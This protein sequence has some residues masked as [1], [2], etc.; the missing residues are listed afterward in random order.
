[1]TEIEIS[2]LNDDLSLRAHAV[3]PG[4]HFGNMA[5]D[6]IIARGGDLESAWHVS[7]T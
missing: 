5:S 3:L 6:V 4:G 2:P 1:M 7:R